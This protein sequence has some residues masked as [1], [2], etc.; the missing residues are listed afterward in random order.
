MN[1]TTLAAVEAMRDHDWRIVGTC[2]NQSQIYMKELGV[3]DD[4]LDHL[5]SHLEAQPSIL[6]AKISGS[7]LGDCVIGLGS[8]EP[9]GLE[10]YLSIPTS[11]S[12]QGAVLETS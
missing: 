1:H 6:G 12:S 8:A 4:T 9:S 11:I 3:S 2:M 7:G 5:V 10:D